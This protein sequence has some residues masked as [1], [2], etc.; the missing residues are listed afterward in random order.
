MLSICLEQLGILLCGQILFFNFQFRGC[1]YFFLFSC[2]VLQQ[3][4]DLH[5]L[6]DLMFGLV[7]ALGD[8]GELLYEGRWLLE[9]SSAWRE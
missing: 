8:V 3:R 9:G 5:H 1:I 7:L 6:A 4:E 2:K